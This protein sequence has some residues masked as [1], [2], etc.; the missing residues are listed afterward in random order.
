MKDNDTPLWVVM[1]A[2][3]LGLAL[4]AFMV[5]ARS[6][7]ESEKPEILIIR[8]ATVDNF[9]GYPIHLLDYMVGGIATNASFHPYEM[10]LYRETMA[11][12]KRSGRLRYA[13]PMIE[14]LGG[15]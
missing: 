7:P 11:Y 5:A 8:M 12:L 3:I 15:E 14:P 13:S 9:D 2:C 1:I 10:D 6:I 4:I